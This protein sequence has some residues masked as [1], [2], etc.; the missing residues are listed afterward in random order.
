MGRRKNTI[1]TIFVLLLSTGGYLL[2]RYYQEKTE[3]IEVTNHDLSVLRMRE[4]LKNTEPTNF[5]SGISYDFRRMIRLMNAGSK[6]WKNLEPTFEN[7]NKKVTVDYEYIASL[8]Q[9]LSHERAKLKNYVWDLKG[10]TKSG[11]PIKEYRSLLY[12]LEVLDG[13]I[14]HM[15]SVLKKKEAKM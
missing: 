2:Y 14:M 12:Y 5:E 7:P 8:L 10:Y 3:T 15:R 9:E 4:L 1:K 13:H 6:I 11:I